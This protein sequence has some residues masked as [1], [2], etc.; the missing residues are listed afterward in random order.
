[1]LNELGFKKYAL[2]G[3]VMDIGWLGLPSVIGYQMGKE[4]GLEM[5]K[6]REAAPDYGVDSFLAHLFVPGAF[7]YQMGKRKAYYRAKRNKR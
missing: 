7:G 6:H 1:M 4:E 3:P 5:A 2:L